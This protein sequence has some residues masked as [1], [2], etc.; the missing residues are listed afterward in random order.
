LPVLPGLLPDRPT[1]A[2]AGVVGLSAGSG[3]LSGKACHWYPNALSAVTA[4][5]INH[6]ANMNF[7][8]RAPSKLAFK[9]I[10]SDNSRANNKTFRL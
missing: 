3:A 1:S 9:G 4:L 5:S 6:P 10:K 2:L 7:I 8:M